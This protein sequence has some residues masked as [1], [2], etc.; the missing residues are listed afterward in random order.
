MAKLELFARDLAMLYREKKR[1]REQ[2]TLFLFFSALRG[3]LIF[4][5]GSS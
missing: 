5:I 3:Q 2:A 4:R 1:F